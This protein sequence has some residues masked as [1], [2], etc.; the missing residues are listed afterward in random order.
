MKNVYRHEKYNASITDFDF[1]LL[2]LADPLTFGK[3]INSIAL[4]NE[5]IK[6]VDGVDALVSGWGNT[7]RSKCLKR[8]YYFILFSVH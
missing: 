2:E 7:N 5:D 4:P 1:S 6:I 8:N 3:T